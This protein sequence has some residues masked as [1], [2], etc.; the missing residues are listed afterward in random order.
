MTADSAC[1]T[2]Y[3]TIEET[4]KLL[5]MAFNGQTEQEVDEVISALGLE[6]LPF[7][8]I[9]AKQEKHKS[10]IVRKAI[11]HGNVFEGI[12]RIASTAQSRGKVRAPH[13]G[14]ALCWQK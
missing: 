5:H 6:S 9:H 10:T 8:D 2:K 1:V 13:P 4:E 12:R 11:P 3:S 7:S 14:I